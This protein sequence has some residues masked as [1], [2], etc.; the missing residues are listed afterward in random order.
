MC[1]SCAAHGCKVMVAE[2]KQ[3][4]EAG[5]IEWLA[6][7]RGDPAMTGKKHKELFASFALAQ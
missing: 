2:A 6:A 3:P 4:S 1:V 7:S 5:A